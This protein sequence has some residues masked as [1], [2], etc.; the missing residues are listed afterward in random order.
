SGVPDAVFAHPAR[1]ICGAASR[2]G[3]VRMAQLALEI[4]A[5]NRTA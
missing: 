3:A 2:E 1:F 4:D 5:A